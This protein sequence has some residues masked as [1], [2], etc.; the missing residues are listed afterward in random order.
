MAYAADCS[1]RQFHAIA[2][3]TT[4]P[5]LGLNDALG[6]QYLLCLSLVSSLAQLSSEHTQ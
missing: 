4:G 5:F 3:F 6:K 1:L 2:T